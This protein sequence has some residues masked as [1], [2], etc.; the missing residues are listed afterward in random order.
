MNEN[1]RSIAQVAKI[2]HRETVA[3]GLEGL[4]DDIRSG[5]V[6]FTAERCVI[7]L[8]ARGAAGCDDFRMT[9]FGADASMAELVGLLELA[10][11]QT[12]VPGG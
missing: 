7:V 3:S 1:V 2:D 6:R 10:K 11:L 5:K 8:S 4:A 12:A 9:Y